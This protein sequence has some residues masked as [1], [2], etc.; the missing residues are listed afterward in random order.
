MSF[1][2]SD[3]AWAEQIAAMSNNRVTYVNVTKPEDTSGV[4]TI[5]VENYVCVCCGKPIEKHQQRKDNMH[6]PCWKVYEP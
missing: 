4:E 3:E 5:H 2:M 1:L 6:I